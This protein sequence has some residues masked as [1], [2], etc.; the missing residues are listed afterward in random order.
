MR[1]PAPPSRAIATPGPNSQGLVVAGDLPK[2]AAL[3]APGQ[4]DLAIAIARQG[5]AA[6]F[7]S[8]MFVAAAAAAFA[9]VLVVALMRPLGAG[10]VPASAE[11]SGK[12]GRERPDGQ[13]GPVL[14]PAPS[15]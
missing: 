14:G 10:R 4:S 2:A 5:Y 11:A 8:A 13:G 15:P 6:G 7:S 9:A 3:L 12:L 1:L